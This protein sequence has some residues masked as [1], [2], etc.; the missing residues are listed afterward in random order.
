[1]AL[2][3]PGRLMSC[4]PRAD[5]GQLDV[6]R[7]PRDPEGACRQRHIAVG[8]GNGVH[9]GLMLHL[10]EAPRSPCRTGLAQPFGVLGQCPGNGRRQ[11]GGID[12]FTIAEGKHGFEHVAEFTDVAGPAIAL[13]CPADRRIQRLRNAAVL[14]RQAPVEMF[15]NGV[16]I[17]GTLPQGR[18]TQ[19]HGTK[20]VIKILPE[21][22]GFDFGKEIPVGGRHD[23]DR[24]LALT[25]I[26]QAY[27]LPILEHPQQVGLQVEGHLAHFIEKERPSI[28]LFKLS[29]QAA[30]AGAREGALD[31]AEELAGQELPRQGTTI[32]GHE[33]TT[34]PPPRPMQGAGKEL[35]ARAL[36]GA[37]GR[38]GGPFVAVNCGALTRE[39]LASELFGY[40]EG[41][42]TG[43]RRGGLAGKFEQADGGTLFLDEV[44]EMPLDLQPHLLRVLQDGQVVRL[45]D[46]RQRKVAVR[47]VAATNRDLL[48]EVEAG[49]FR[50][51]LYHRLCAVSLSLP[52]LRERPG[53]IDTIVE[54]LNR[55][56]A[57]KYGCVPKALDPAVRGAFQCYRWPGNI[58]E[59]R[60]VFEAMFALSDG[61][62]I[63]AAQL[64]PAIARA[65]AE[66]AE[67]LGKP[68]A[69]GGTGRLEQVEHQAVVDAIAHAHGNMSLAARTLGISRSTLYV[70]LAAIRA[71]E[72]RH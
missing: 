24:H 12:V 51:D 62:H 71:R 50:E 28:G 22:P 41:A 20:P 13:K 60:N 35:F 68:C 38:P 46:V 14:G 10:L 58:R 54:H 47:I 65:L 26:P 53:D 36:H 42:F 48:T 4:L 63:D 15:H 52:A 6:E 31:V 37:G 56:L 21:A 23:A 5:G 40:V 8:M 67:G 72:A 39:L 44:G 33:G 9:H 34:G 2:V 3:S 27:H 45:G 55:S 70:K 66:H 64:P 43:A 69:A 7:T 61:E 17:T 18:Q 29:C 57:A 16:D 30:P 59:L 32:D 49:R 11:L 19:A 1:M 25:D